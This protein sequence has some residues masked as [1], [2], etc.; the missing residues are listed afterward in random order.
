MKNIK[1]SKKFKVIALATCMVLSPISIK[2]E[3]YANNTSIVQNEKDNDI[4]LIDL[5]NTYGAIYSIK[6]ECLLDYVEFKT[7]GYCDLIDNN[8]VDCV[9][10]LPSNLFFGTSIATCIMTLKKNK[11]DNQFY[12]AIQVGCIEV[13]VIML[14]GLLTRHSGKE[15]T[16]QYRR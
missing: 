16:C 8:F 14:M 5:C 10:Q 2:K 12:P 1:I 7:N 3:V 15:S 9:I 11:K 6:P 13:C 4:S